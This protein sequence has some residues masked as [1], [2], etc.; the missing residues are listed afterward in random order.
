MRR[1]LIV[2]LAGLL[3][4][5][6][7]A[8]AGAAPPHRFDFPLEVNFPDFENG[9]V[10]FV[11][12]SRATYCTD[13]VVAF[14]ETL[15]AFFN[16]EGPPPEEPPIPESPT[17]FPLG[18]EPITVQL[19]ETRQGAQVFHVNEEDLYIEIWEIDNDPGFVGP[20]LDTDGTEAALASGTTTY[21]RQDN[22]LFGSGT[23][24]NSFGDRG[25]AVL[26]GGGSYE[27]RFHLNN[28]CYAPEGGPPTCLLEVG[29][30]VLP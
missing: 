2:V 24:G 20:C 1:V 28:R 18:L 12:S 27:W 14:E 4:G 5:A 3:A 9:V 22:D 21:Q 10:V 26:D 13:E 17:G 16:G 23:R 30:L 8:P 6:M 29:N 7:A 15:V 19:K 11:N 25:Q